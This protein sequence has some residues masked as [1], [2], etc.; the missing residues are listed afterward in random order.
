MGRL[1]GKV[2]VITG[3]SAGIGLAIAHRFVREGARVF[4]TG[5]REAELAAAVLKLGRAATGVPGDAAEVADL[6]RLFARV[7]AA[8]SPIDVLVANAGGGGPAGG[9]ADC[10]E[11]RFDSV[12]DLNF[13][14]TFFTVQRALPYLRDGASV[15]LL[16]SAAG[17]AASARYGVYAAAKAAVRSLARSLALELAG[18]G[19]RVN[20]LSPGPVETPSL[21]AAPADLRARVTAAVPLGR[22]GRPEEVAAAALF[23]AS[24]ESSF[25]TGIELP[26]DGGA[27]QV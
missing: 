27:G 2:A 10:T 15:V 26:V 17:S 22:A 20:A 1:D 23:L 4:V 9:F 8:G 12:S 14:G 11:E 5:R 16:G 7:A 13:R 3:G 21:A 19:I 6:D 24:A 18:R 25:I